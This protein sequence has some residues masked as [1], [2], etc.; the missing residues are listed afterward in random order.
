LKFFP[1]KL[2]LKIMPYLNYQKNYVLVG[3]FNVSR[4]VQQSIKSEENQEINITDIFKKSTEKL[5]ITNSEM[6]STKFLL[7]LSEPLGAQIYSGDRIMLQDHSLSSVQG[8]AVSDFEHFFP[9]S[10]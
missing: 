5:T 7:K 2:G 6:Y 9:V 3:H 8:P 4:Q 10:P 1:Q